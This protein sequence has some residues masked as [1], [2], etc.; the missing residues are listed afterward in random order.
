MVIQVTDGV[1]QVGELGRGAVEIVVKGPVGIRIAELAGVGVGVFPPLHRLDDDAKELVAVTE[2][3]VEGRRDRAAVP[4]FRAQV[5]AQA[6]DALKVL[7]PV[8]GQAAGNVTVLQLLYMEWAGP[9]TA[10]LIA[11]VRARLGAE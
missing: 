5:G 9:V 8:H 7:R 10:L 1:P 6:S 11:E 4:G 3:R 2:E